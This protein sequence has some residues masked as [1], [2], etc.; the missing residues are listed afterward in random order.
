MASLENYTKSYKCF[1]LAYMKAFILTLRFF[2][3]LMLSLTN[4]KFL[5]NIWNIKMLTNDLLLQD[6]RPVASYA[7]LTYNS[8]DQLFSLSFC[9]F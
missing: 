1:K 7:I 9:Y 6:G 2:L 8:A 4:V 3:N 5:C